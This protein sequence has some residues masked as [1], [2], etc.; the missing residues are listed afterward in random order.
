LSVYNYEEGGNGEVEMYK[1]LDILAL[2]V[3]NI[4]DLRTRI[5]SLEARIAELE[6]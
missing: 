4:K 1:H 3:A 2:S 5:S 6:G